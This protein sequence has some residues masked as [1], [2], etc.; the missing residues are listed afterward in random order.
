MP[1][2]IFNSTYY[3]KDYRAGAALLRA[4]R[5]YLF[6]NAATGLALCAFTIG[7]YAYTIRAV[8]QDEFSDVKVPDA[9]AT[10]PKQQ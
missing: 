10:S 6:K 4:R 3:G 5:P 1:V 2:G 7:V 9:P 8:G